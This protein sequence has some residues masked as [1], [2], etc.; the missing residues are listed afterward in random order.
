VFRGV[1]DSLG[2]V[3][4]GKALVN[5]LG[6]TGVYCA[7][8]FNAPNGDG[9]ELWDVDFAGDEGWITG[10]VGTNTGI[11]IYSSDRGATW[12]QV[13]YVE[14]KSIFLADTQSSR[15]TPTTYGIAALG[16][17]SAFSVAYASYTYAYEGAGVA[18]PSQ[19]LD[20]CSCTSVCTPLTSVS[21]PTMVQIGPAMDQALAPPLTAA[22]A[23][24]ASN[25]WAVGR[26]GSLRSWDATNSEWDDEGTEFSVRITDGDFSSSTT[27]CM[28]GQGLRIL[29]TTDGG[30]TWTMV[31]DPTPT[32]AGSDSFEAVDLQD[33]GSKGVAVG[34]ASSV[35]YTAD[36][37]ATW[38]DV[39]PLPG[40][41][42]VRD[43]THI[44][45]TNTFWAVGDSGYLAKSS[46]GG[47]TWSQVTASNGSG[48]S[49]TFDFK[50]IAFGDSSIGRLRGY[51]VGDDE[52]VIYTSNGGVTWARVGIVGGATSGIDLRSVDTWGDAVDAVAVGD[53][54][55]FLERSGGGRFSRITPT[56]ANA[57][58]NGLNSVTSP[59]SGTTYWAAGDAGT[60]IRFDGTA[61]TDFK[62]QTRENLFSAAFD[63]ADHGFI[64]GREFYC[65]EFD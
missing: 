18:G 62:T 12:D 16:N 5:Q 27:G 48:G 24:D 49:Y 32:L 7:D 50:S 11:I 38:T 63:A 56:T 47:A 40:S 44:A 19:I 41:P 55:E 15:S 42:T 22:E 37:G 52:R 23:L 45:A 1:I 14:P 21:S 46:D 61:W 65:A 34:E 25:R 35:A 43:V 20:L 57:G 51:V 6:S 9:F 8:E 60:A 58:G 30:A 54:G 26:F 39:S 64:V 53:Q 31:Y 10:G 3:T 17:G 28:V 4:W 13:Q 59:D 36:G 2:N 33:G 29:R